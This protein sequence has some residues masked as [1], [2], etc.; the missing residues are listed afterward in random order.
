MDL[1]H[2]TVAS[3]QIEC[4]IAVSL[5]PPACGLLPHVSLTEV[6]L[7]HDA[8]NALEIQF[9]I[10]CE[11]AVCSAIS[12]STLCACSQLNA[13]RLSSCRESVTCT[14]EYSGAPSMLRDAPSKA[15]PSVTTL[16]PCDV[17]HDNSSVPMCRAS[18][19]SGRTS[20]SWHVPHQAK[21]RRPQKEPAQEEPRVKRMLRQ[22][23]RDR[24]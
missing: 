6:G 4:L 8:V 16:R 22:G 13:G 12:G 21:Q 23:H 3:F 19:P 24:R 1:Q 2:G 15:I 18:H 20:A 14:K 17:L 9:L 11:P 7:L 5:L 10:A